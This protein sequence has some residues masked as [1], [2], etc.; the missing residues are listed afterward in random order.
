ML[1]SHLIEKEFRTNHSPRNPLD[2]DD[3]PWDDWYEKGLEEA[4]NESQSFVIV[5]DQG[6]DSSTWM[7]IEA[8]QALRKADTSGDNYLMAYWNP[9]DIEVKAKGVL[10][11]LIDKL[12]NEP[13]K[14][15]EALTRQMRATA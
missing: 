8:D 10:G 4:I 2:G 15:I 14:A 13:D 6:W 7:S 9:N 3:N 12:P 1:I 5:V 11:Y